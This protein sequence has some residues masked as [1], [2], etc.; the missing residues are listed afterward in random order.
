MRHTTKWT[1]LSSELDTNGGAFTVLDT[2]RPNDGIS[3]VL[4]A[5]H[6]KTLVNAVVAY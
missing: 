4:E 5:A 1:N 3:I 2:Q 6:L